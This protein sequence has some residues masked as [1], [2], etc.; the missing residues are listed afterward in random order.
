MHFKML[1]LRELAWTRKEQLDN[2]QAKDQWHGVYPFRLK[3]L[4]LGKSFES[5]SNVHPDPRTVIQS[6]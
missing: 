6:N 5:V 1:A 3:L 4:E 2:R